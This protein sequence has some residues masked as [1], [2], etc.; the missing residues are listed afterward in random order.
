MTQPHYSSWMVSLFLNDPDCY[1]REVLRLIKKLRSRLST[2]E[3]ER[4]LGPLQKQLKDTESE[5]S[6]EFDRLLVEND[7][8]EG[9][10]G[11]R[12]MRAAS[13]AYELIKLGIK[14]PD[15]IPVE[16]YPEFWIWF[17]DL[18]EQIRQQIWDE[19]S[20]PI[21]ENHA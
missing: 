1:N 19:A 3:L 5:L 17:G 15:G 9:L 6:C 21:A 14:I 7:I 13:A 2:Q 16:D 4:I 12:R 20:Y 8:K 11:A 10:R 18:P